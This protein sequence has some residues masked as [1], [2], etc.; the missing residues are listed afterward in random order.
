MNLTSELEE[1]LEEVPEEVERAVKRGTRWRALRGVFNIVFLWNY[2]RKR[3][4]ASDVMREFCKC[5]VET[6]R[7]KERV[8]AFNKKVLRLQRTC[9]RFLAKKKQWCD[10]AHEG[11]RGRVQ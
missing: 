4:A 11:A 9:R 6:R 3:R 5:L 7:M 2:V 10:Q 1:T 8:A